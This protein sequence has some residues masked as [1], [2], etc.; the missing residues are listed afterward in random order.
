MGNTGQITGQTTTD[1]NDAPNQAYCMVKK[2]WSGT[3]E[4]APYLEP[5]RAT[6]VIAPGISEAVLAYNFG[7]IKR[8]KKTSFKVYQPQA[9]I[10]SFVKIVY[11]GR[12]KS[13]DVWFGIITDD[14]RQPYGAIT[15]PSGK[16]LMTAR[17][18]E[19]LLDRVQI[20]TA[21]VKQDSDIFEIKWCPDFNKRASYGPKLLGNRSSSK[22]TGEGAGG[23]VY[24]YKDD[25]EKWNHLNVAEYL[26]EYFQP[27][28]LSSGSS[29]TKGL[30]KLGGQFQAMA[31]L[32]SI[33]EYEGQ[34]VKQLFDALASRERGLFW[35]VQP[36]NDSLVIYI[37]SVHGMAIK[38]GEKEFPANQNIKKKLDFDN[39]IYYKD[40]QIL[41]SRTSR[42]DEIRVQGNRIKTCFAISFNDED[43]EEAWTMGDDQ[44][45]EQHIYENS[46]SELERQQDQR[47]EY[48][49][50]RK[51][52]DEDTDEVYATNRVFRMFRIPRD[53]DWKAGNGLGGPDED[54]G[55]A[56]HNVIPLL[57]NNAQLQLDGD[58]IKSP[59]DGGW[60]WKKSFLRKLPF[61]L[62]TKKAKG[63]PEYRDPIVIVRDPKKG[64]RFKF[65][66]SD[67][68]TGATIRMVDRELAIDCRMG[69]NHRL[70]LNRF[71][72]DI[73]IPVTL[74]KPVID[75]KT[76]IATVFLE[77][78][79]RPVVIVKVSDQPETD[80]KRTLVIKVPDVEFH[81]V[82][83]NTPID[84]RP[85]EL[86]GSNIAG[87]KYSKLIPFKPAYDVADDASIAEM[88]MAKYNAHVVRD[89][90]DF[91][92][93]IAIFAKAWYGF[94]HSAIS[95]SR[96]Y[97]TCL[98]YL[99]MYIKDVH[100]G[101][102]KVESNS[103][104]S[105]VGWNFQNETTDIQTDFVELDF[106][107][108]VD[109]PGMSD[110]R[111]V[112][113]KFKGMQGQIS[114]LEGHVNNMPVKIPHPP[115]QGVSD[116]KH[117]HRGD[118]DQ[119]TYVTRFGDGMQGQYSDM[120]VVRAVPN[121]SA[122]V[123]GASDLGNF[124]TLQGWKYF[125]D[126][127][128]LTTAPD[129][130]RLMW[131]VNENFV[132]FNLSAYTSVAANGG[133]SALAREG[134][135][136]HVV[137]P[138]TRQEFEPNDA[139]PIPKKVGQIG[140]IIY[141]DP[142]NLKTITKDKDLVL[143]ES[144]R[145]DAQFFLDMF[146]DGPIWFTRR[147][148]SN[149]KENGFTSIKGE[150]AFDPT[151]KDSSGGHKDHNAGVFRPFIYVHYEVDYEGSIPIIFRDNVGFVDGIT[152]M[153]NDRVHLW[154]MDVDSNGLLSFQNNASGSFQTALAFDSVN[155]STNNTTTI[156]RQ[157]DNIAPGESLVEGFAYRMTGS[158]ADM[159]R[160][161]TGLTY[162]IFSIHS[163]D[164]LDN[165]GR[166]KSWDF[167]FAAFNDGANAATGKIYPKNV[168][169]AAYP[170]DPLGGGT[171]PFTTID[172]EFSGWTAIKI[173]DPVHLRQ[174]S[175]SVYSTMDFYRA[176][177]GPAIVLDTDVL[178]RFAAYGWD[179]NSYETF[180]AIEFRVDGT[181]GDGDA[182]GSIALM[183]SDDGGTT[184]EDRVVIENT[185]IVRLENDAKCW[186][187]I[188]AQFTEGSSI[189]GLS[190]PVL[191]Q[192]TDDGG[193]SVGVYAYLFGKVGDRHIISTPEVSHSIKKGSTVYPHMHYAPTA[194]PGTD[195]VVTLE[196]EHCIVNIDEQ[197]GNSTVD[198]DDVTI[199]ASG[200][201]TNYHRIHEFA[202]ITQSCQ[203]NDILPSAVFLTRG[204][205]MATSG[206]DDYGDDIFIFNL[207]FHYEID[208]QGT[209]T[210]DHTAK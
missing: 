8:E 48:K 209:R 175:D 183:V 86:S 79:E 49:D 159:Y 107:K 132:P 135:W 16:Q 69:M 50:K 133:P 77:T 129:D 109:F 98:D 206:A 33:I 149:A 147:D 202:A 14:N 45:S 141:M 117:V 24:H 186:D 121:V 116:L 17:G 15:E 162:G 119:S 146:H 155:K 95:F 143:V 185:G 35:Y 74:D 160:Y 103:I 57:D 28:G 84:L 105:S 21:W 174:E 26:L 168:S 137:Q 192:V 96:E 9:L 32:E 207:D 73:K 36:D 88:R 152:I 172:L 145:W 154:Q 111:S 123:D 11:S 151:L 100:Y 85:E 136:M 191:N 195:E 134:G 4:P 101:N 156:F 177:S 97:I 43:L 5:L 198:S 89:D 52:Q 87:S 128:N 92:R 110:A 113:K 181:P 46:L 169:E 148:L 51:N 6:R 130:Y 165:S 204:A 196:I 118:S 44:D 108:A 76:I 10:D 194:T 38:D 144:I 81:Y 93:E 124:D 164:V 65:F 120:L 139:D 171:N 60:L 193:G 2:A 203:A 127:Y 163:V 210:R 91:L 197:I 188:I 114:A 190:G 122:I 82:V 71:D 13:A 150:M 20:N 201:D 94:N 106:S 61:E 142:T 184:L 167:R 64:N 187:D 59:P 27:E 72:P 67:H 176:R 25:G 166:D 1:T 131:R 22:S 41:R 126:E 29:P 161:A 199:P 205:R 180:C 99:G 47:V 138:S 90:T 56:F 208:S 40:P 39:D 7:S 104:V 12:G 70:A 158:D 23:S 58:D 19:Y 78:D 115:P 125:G 112:S 62:E 63:E 173:Y 182:P 157:T 68:L 80:A 75:Y 83:P 102:Q 55:E 54:A 18:L 200:A 66:D 42:F 153:D 37:D 179:S 53:W 189:P 31:T 140:D 3:W 34:S 170:G 30:F 178:G